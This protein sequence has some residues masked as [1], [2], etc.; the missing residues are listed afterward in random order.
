MRVVINVVLSARRSPCS[1]STRKRLW[2]VVT[3]AA[4]IW[5]QLPTMRMLMTSSQARGRGRGRALVSVSLAIA[6]YTTVRATLLACRE[7]AK[8][9]RSA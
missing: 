5:N 8:M 3:V 4:V 6:A 7:P 9:E 1:C 2:V